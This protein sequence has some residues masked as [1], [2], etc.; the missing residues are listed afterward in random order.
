MGVAVMELAIEAV[1]IDTLISDPDNARLHNNRNRDAVRRS[2]KQFGIRKPIVAHERTKIVYAGN[3]TLKRNHQL[4]EIL[5]F[6]FVFF[7][8][9]NVTARTA[10]RTIRNLRTRF[11]RSAIHTF[12][13]V[14]PFGAVFI[15]VFHVT[16]FAT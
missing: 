6:S 12:C 7:F 2:I 16:R 8:Y 10:T 3:L 4:I 5:I 11:G 9:E 1:D 15:H 13:V 14:N